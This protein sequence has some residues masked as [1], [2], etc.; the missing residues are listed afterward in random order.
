MVK[1]KKRVNFELLNSL[2]SVIF[3]Q[4]YTGIALKSKPKKLLKSNHVYL[5]ELMLFAS[6]EPKVEN[7]DVIN[8]GLAIMLS[9]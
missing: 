6:K 4:R 1:K 2:F 5:V 9:S 3:S 8:A 7:I